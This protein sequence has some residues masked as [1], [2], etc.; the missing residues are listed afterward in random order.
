MAAVAKTRFA[1]RLTAPQFACTAT[2]SPSKP[3]CQDNRE[4]YF[5]TNGV[6]ATCNTCITIEKKKNM[7]AACKHLL[8]TSNIAGLM[9]CV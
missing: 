5:T 3:A 2:E 4:G 1:K 9:Q 7:T 8:L 6:W